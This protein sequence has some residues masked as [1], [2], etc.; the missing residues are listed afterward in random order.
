MTASGSA[1]TPARTLLE[2]LIRERQQTLEEFAEDAEKFAREHDE[3]GTLSVRHLQRLIAGTRPDG[4]PLGPVRP[5][6]ARLLQ[7]IFGLS[8]Q[9]LLS[10]PR[11]MPT[12]AHP[13][14]VAVAI[15]TKSS[16]VLVVCR[17]GHEGNG[18]T[19]Q[20]PAGLVKPGA[21][22][23]MVAVRETLDETGVHC[24][25]T[26]NLG[27]RLHPVTKVVCDYILCDYVTGEA[28]NVDV[29]ENVD[30]V[31][32]GKADVT[33]MIPEDQIYGPVMRA[34]KEGVPT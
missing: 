32:I 33:R 11:K 26:R 28:K 8:V 4:S 24:V 27:T 9:E 31:W 6:T 2:Q 20:F 3:P 5:A 14:R 30:V 17:R 12:M 7:R 15:V 16:E 1:D 10:P 34:L 18:I 21:S 22:A 19:W 25:V 29:V 13:L 23:Q